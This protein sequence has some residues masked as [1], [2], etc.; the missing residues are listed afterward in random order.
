MRKIY[1]NGDFITLENNEIE[2]IV[3]ENDKIF[4]KTYLFRGANLCRGY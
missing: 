4:K 1:I 3:I 2:G